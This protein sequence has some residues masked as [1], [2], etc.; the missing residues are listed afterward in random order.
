VSETVVSDAVVSD[1]VVSDAVVSDAV[2][3][4]TAV[5]EE[6]SDDSQAPARDAREPSSDDA[7]STRGVEVP[8]AEALVAAVRA[9]PEPSLIALDVDGTLAPIVTDPAAARVPSATRAALRR[10]AARRPLAFVT[11]RDVAGLRRVLGAVPNAWRVVEHG[12]WTIPPGAHARRPTVSAE[13]RAR[14]DA[15][16]A[17]VNELVQAHG[18]RLERKPRAAALHVRGLAAEL[19]ASLLARAAERARALG[20]HARE[21]RAVL[22]AELAPGDKGEALAALRVRT[23]TRGVFFA[24][25]DLTDLPAIRYASEHGLGVFV[26][27]AERDAPPGVPSVSASM[28]AAALTQLADEA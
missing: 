21:G 3:S 24:G 19:Q 20:L 22:E 17:F 6:G 26:R 9:L 8:S 1:V 7:K 23:A 15:F 5:S 10:I 18:G 14:L 27:S 4:E 2:V 25:D 16:A 28:L 13:E 12:G 11:G